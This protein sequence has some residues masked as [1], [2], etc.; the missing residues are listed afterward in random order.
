MLKNRV[1]PGRVWAAGEVGT[2]ELKVSRLAV[3]VHENT[4]RLGPLRFDGEATEL[5]PVPVDK[6]AALED[7][8]LGELP[9]PQALRRLPLLIRLAAHAPAEAGQR[10]E[11]HEE[12][13][14]GLLVDEF[15]EDDSMLDRLAAKKVAEDKIKKK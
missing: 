15:E 5:E 10:A 9:R 1:V 4:S 2:K 12:V 13:Q 14:A 7:Q 3:A 6:V 8:W 11:E